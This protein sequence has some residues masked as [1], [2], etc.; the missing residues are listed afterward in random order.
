VP[1]QAHGSGIPLFLVAAG[2]EAVSFARY[3][4][5]DQPLYGVRGPDSPAT[6][7]E[8]A[9]TS[10]RAIRRARPQGPYALAGWCSSGLIALETARQLQNSGAHVSFVALFDA[11]TV[12]L[13]PMSFGQLALVRAWR[14]LQRVRF[15]LARVRRQG[16]SPI[17]VAVGSRARS[18]EESLRAERGARPD[19][20]LEA[21]RNYRP[22][23][24]DGRAV[25][26][27]A[28]DRPRGRFQD[29]E[30]LW[31]SISPQGFK[32]YEVPGDHLTMLREPHVHRVAMILARE[33]RQAKH[34][35]RATEEFAEIPSS[36]Y[37]RF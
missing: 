30:F 31:R 27:W 17:R 35:Q 5:P 37:G 24:W 28:A 18:L 10:A 7:Q 25:H 8:I 22:I 21:L 16:W 26:I 14:Y 15:F 1:I 2:F 9:E 23:P 11:R 12:F 19:I 34:A 32:F 4:G 36:A 20:V 29:P 13:P 6:F 3:L 33:L